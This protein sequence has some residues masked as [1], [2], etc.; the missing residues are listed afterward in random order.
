MIAPDPAL[1]F[2]QR[3]ISKMA[4]ARIRSLTKPRDKENHELTRISV[5]KGAL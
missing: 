1:A 5:A 3:P 4:A 2:G